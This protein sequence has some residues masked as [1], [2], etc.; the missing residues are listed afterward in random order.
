MCPSSRCRGRRK[1]SPRVACRARRTTTGCRPAVVLY[2]HPS[3]LSADATNPVG[4]D[5]SGGKPVTYPG[6]MT[7]AQ[8]EQPEDGQSA[9]RD[10]SA[11]AT[12]SD[13]AQTLDWQWLPTA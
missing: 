7:S 8:H 4:D 2:S 9:P 1:W 5:M 11:A 6:A 10:E 12:E 3:T 13:A